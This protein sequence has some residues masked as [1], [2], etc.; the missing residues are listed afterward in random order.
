MLRQALDAARTQEEEQLLVVQPLPGSAS[1]GET[2]SL[3]PESNTQQSYAATNNTDNNSEDGESRSQTQSYDDDEEWEEAW[4][5][6]HQNGPA[7]VQVGLV[8]KIWQ[9]VKGCF[10]LVLNVE[11][12][13]DSPSASASSSERIV[14]PGKNHCVV[15]FWFFVLAASYASERST[16]KLLVDRTGP[17]RLFTVE[18]IT[19]SHALMVGMGMLISAIARK[20]FSMKPL[21]IPIVDVGCKFSSSVDCVVCV[22]GPRT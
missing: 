13:W 11:N 1:V 18:V 7:P 16:F 9:R 14:V 10:F 15:L 6:R 19:F 17:F 2:D 3:L 21:G 8:E 22:L 12:L 4:R 20:D 5:N